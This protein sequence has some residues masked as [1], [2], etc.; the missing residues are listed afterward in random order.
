MN[1]VVLFL[2]LELSHRVSKP[3]HCL[4]FYGNEW[5]KV[6]LVGKQNRKFKKVKVTSMCFWGNLSSG[7]GKKC[8]MTLDILFSTRIVE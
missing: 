5:N 8:A 1:S 7:L 3:F 4:S 6:D 2:K